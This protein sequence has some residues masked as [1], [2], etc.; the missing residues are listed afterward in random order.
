M[1]LLLLLHCFISPTLFAGVLCWSLFCY[2]LLCVLCSFVI[3]V[4]KEERA[5]FSAD[6][7][8]LLVFV[9]LSHGAVC[10]PAVCDCCIS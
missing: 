4:N 10:W 8:R 2:V 5:G 1:G 7:L 3:V 9:A 6:T